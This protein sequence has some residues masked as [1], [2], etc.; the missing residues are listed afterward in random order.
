MTK[1][2]KQVG[3][4]KVIF[5]DSHK[6]SSIINENTGFQSLWAKGFDAQEE[7]DCVQKMND[8][9]FLE[10][11]QVIQKNLSVFGMDN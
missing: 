9:Q 11:C 5:D 8:Y 6:V 2:I 7:L 10:Y 3:E 1:K 4:W